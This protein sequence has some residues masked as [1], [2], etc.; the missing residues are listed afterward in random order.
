MNLNFSRHLVTID[1]LNSEL[2]A[3]NLSI[4]NLEKTKN[5][6]E[7]SLGEHRQWLQDASNRSQF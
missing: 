3:K 4:E 2:T 7:W 5:D 1:A 6:T